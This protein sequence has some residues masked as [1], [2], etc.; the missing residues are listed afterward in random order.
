MWIDHRQMKR[1][2]TLTLLGAS[3]ACWLAAC[4]MTR[5]PETAPADWEVLDKKALAS[6]RGR[7]DFAT[8]VKPVLEAKCLACHNRQ[9]PPPPFFSLENRKLAFKAGAAGARIVPGYPEKSVLI[10]NATSAHA[11]SMPPVGERLTVE[12]KRILTAW[13]QQGANWPAGP[14]GELHPAP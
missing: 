14:A 4:T 12:E 8:H 10:K 3:L 7:I 2:S 5:H 6:S 11:H 1:N 13:V 9:H